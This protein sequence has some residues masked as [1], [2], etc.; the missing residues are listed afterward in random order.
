MAV[1]VHLQVL[2]TLSRKRRT[3]YG[4]VQ[5]CLSVYSVFQP[6]KSCCNLPTTL[7]TT[8]S[9]S[10]CP[11]VIARERVRVFFATFSCESSQKVFVLE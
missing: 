8:A 11:H 4:P 7:G 5:V 10:D 9:L 6:M 3:P 1:V 2:F